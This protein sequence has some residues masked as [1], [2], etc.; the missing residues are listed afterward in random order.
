[1]VL[2]KLIVPG[3]MN[4]ASIGQIIMSLAY[5]SIYSGYAINPIEG[6]NIGYAVHIYPGWF[7][8]GEGYDNF[9]HYNPG[10]QWG[11]NHNPV[12][13]KWSLIENPGFLRLYTASVTESLYSAKNTLAQRILGFPSDKNNSYATIKIEIGDMKDGKE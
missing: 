3:L 1:M 10:L 2:H 6:D 11:W 7:G 9:C 4:E 5:Q 8:S 12:D 13:S